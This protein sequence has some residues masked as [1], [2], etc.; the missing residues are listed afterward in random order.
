VLSPLHA[1]LDVDATARAGWTVEGLAQAFLDGG[2]R[3]IQLRAKHLSSAAF[4]EH[5]ERLVHA[6]RPYGARIVINDRVDIA[7]LAG[8]AG[9][10]VGQ[11]DL[12]PA[13]ARR[14]LGTEAIVGWST[15]TPGQIEAAVAEPLTYIA[16]GP[17]FGTATKD[18]GYAPVGLEAVT[19]AARIAGRIPVVAI[20]G[21]TLETAGDVMAAGA[22]GVAV[23]GDLLA[24]GDPGARVA[25]FGRI[26]GL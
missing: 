10:H 7:R 23:I 19:R 11:D 13:A 20:G 14:L 1:I 16:I 26:L 21:I 5:A 25:A 24:G 6:A 15:H 17:V 2:A 9:A 4:F 12:P 8:A 22:S 3:V 18:T